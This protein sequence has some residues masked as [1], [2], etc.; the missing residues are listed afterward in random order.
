MRMRVC[1]KLC[2]REGGRIDHSQCKS[3]T[4]TSRLGSTNLFCS[5]L[6][7]SPYLLSGLSADLV[8]LVD[9]DRVGST[10]VVTSDR[11]DEE[12]DGN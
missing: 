8:F 2:V 7:I 5:I 1:V 12:D 3:K 4:F 6:A 10:G 9:G 11:V